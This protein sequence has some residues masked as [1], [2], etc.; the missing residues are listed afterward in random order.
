MKTE[1]RSQE[2]GVRNQE[3]RHGFTLIELLVV[4]ALIAILAALIIP[5]TAAVNRAKILSVARG[6]LAMLETGIQVYK[7]ERGFYP[8]DN[9]TTNAQGA[10]CY[11]TN[12]LYYEL[13]GTRAT[14]QFPTLYVTL[15]GSARLYESQIPEVFFNKTGFMNAS[16][17]GAGDEMANATPCLRGLKP[18]QVGQFFVNKIYDN[19]GPL[20]VKIIVGP[21]W[22]D[23]PTSII[24]GTTFNPFRYN[25][26][27]PTN[28]PSSYDLWID[29]LIAGK[30]N[31]ISN[32]SSKPIQVY[33]PGL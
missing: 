24:P 2:S 33:S 6:D 25:S 27:S 13:L 10:Y 7:S 16:R 4:I 31:R 15:D 1:D 12:Q 21:P 9:P 17:T 29:V 11:T 5:I 22:P 19:N 18:A 3:T 28:N 23:P 8:P 20:P 14:N 26:S 30:T 32:W